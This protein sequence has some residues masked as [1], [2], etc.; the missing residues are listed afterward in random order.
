MAAEALRQDRIVIRASSYLCSGRSFS[1]RTG[2]FM[3]NRYVSA[4]PLE[5]KERDEQ[6]EKCMN[7]CRVKSGIAGVSASP[8]D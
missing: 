4:R 8:V 5:I 3:R 1:F 7:F 2:I 6:S